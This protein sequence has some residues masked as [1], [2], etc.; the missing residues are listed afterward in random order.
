VAGLEESHS[1][2]RGDQQGRLMDAVRLLTP[3]AGH[4]AVHTTLVEAELIDVK[5]ASD[6]ET[7]VGRQPGVTRCNLPFEAMGP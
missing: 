6:L 1:E 3:P 7:R 2:S 4:G 5:N